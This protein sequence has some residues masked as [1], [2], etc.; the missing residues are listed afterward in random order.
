MVST[1]SPFDCYLVNR[2]I[3]TL[4]LRMDNHCENGKAVAR[5]LEKYPKVLKVLHPGLLSHPQYELAKKQRS[6]HS[7]M[8]VIQL[9]GKSKRC[10]K[11]S[12]RFFEF[13]CHWIVLELA[14]VL[15]YR[16]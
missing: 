1:C 6:G 2:G 10:R 12:F 9:H 8:I 14:L 3:K 5:F 11:K 15:L 7:G 13:L 16:E 4:G